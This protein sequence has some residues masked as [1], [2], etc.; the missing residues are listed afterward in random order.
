MNHNKINIAIHEHLGW[1]PNGRGYWHKD[2]QVRASHDECED[3]SGRH[4][5]TARL[6]DYCADLNAIVGLVSKLLPPK[7]DTYLQH[8]SIIV[9]RERRMTTT[10]WLCITATP[11]Q[12]TEAYLKTEGIWSNDLYV[13]LDEYPATS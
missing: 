5:P 8:L 4:Q 6:I 7:R 10:S 9:N 1:K 2:G 11:I 12:H 3:D 13:N